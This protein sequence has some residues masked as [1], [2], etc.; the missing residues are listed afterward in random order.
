MR[1]LLALALGIAAAMTLMTVPASAWA[2]TTHSPA[3]TLSFTE[4]TVLSGDHPQ[5]RYSATSLASG[6]HLFLQLAYGAPSQWTYVESLKA[7]AGV[8]T[9]PALPTGVY[10]FR[11]TALYGVNPVAVSPAK[12]LSVV[13]PP[14]SSCGICQFFGG[15]GGAVASWL[16]NDALPWVLGKLPLPW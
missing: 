5:L 10:R 8:A 14:S 12:V 6:S 4:Q 13:S 9:I 15:I 2:S 3:I 1:K 7:A 11:V 16:L